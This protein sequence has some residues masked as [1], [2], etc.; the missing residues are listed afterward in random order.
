[1]KIFEHTNYRAIVSLNS[2]NKDKWAVRFDHWYLNKKDFLPIHPIKNGSYNIIHFQSK[3]NC[4]YQNDDIFKSIDIL[5]EFLS[6]KKFIITYGGSMGAYAAI[7]FSGVLGAQCT[8]ALSPQFSLSQDFRKIAGDNRWLLE[9]QNY[10]LDHIKDSSEKI[11]KGLIIYDPLHHQDNIHAEHILKI[12]EQFPLKING[13][14]HSPA[15]IL[16]N[17]LNIKINDLVEQTLEL[18]EN[19]QDISQFF[20]EKQ[21]FIDQHNYSKFINMTSL[22][23]INILNKDGSEN[24][25]FK[26][27]FKLMSHLFYIFQF[28]KISNLENL[29]LLVA[30]SNFSDNP[31]EKKIIKEFLSNKEKYKNLYKSLELFFK[32]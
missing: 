28:Q 30:K 14:W 15:E 7:A 16:D 18:L 4:W 8:I 29:E 6:D 23:K 17:I 5:K 22:E 1:M 2:T 20:Q 25:E 24:E 3:N 21:K 11:I 19:G 10:S 9:T 32:N 27:I 26:K 31:N 13:G 12:S